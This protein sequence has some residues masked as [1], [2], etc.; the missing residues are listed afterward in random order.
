MV[1]TQRE[2]RVAGLLYT[3]AC[4]PAPFALIYVPRVL[5]VP[6]DATATAD[7]V[8]AS[9]SL[10]RMSIAGE[11]FNSILLIFAV[12]ALYRLF[13][14]VNAKLASAMAALIL[15]SVPVGLLNIVNHIAPLILV[16]G[17]NFLSA[18]PKSQLDTL[19]YLFLRLHSQGL[20]VAQ[21][22]WGLWLFPY[23]LLIIR[24]GFIP[25]WIGVSLYIAGAGYLA[26]SCAALFL[27]QVVRVVSQVSV[28]LAVAEFP[29]IVW[30]LIWGVKAKPSE[31]PVLSS[32]EQATVAG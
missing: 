11:L 15:I 17:A 32:R 9:A 7:R 30:L 31:A 8:R 10:L 29:I 19:T 4:A 28:V 26:S 14:P 16:S 13:K 1:P 2:A 22:F 25:R 5:M 18:F 24:S 23:G 27:P 20:L 6:G 21:I 3:L 12:L